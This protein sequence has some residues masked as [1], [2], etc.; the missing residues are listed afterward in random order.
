MNHKQ[1]GAAAVEFAL[2]APAV[3]LIIFASFEYLRVTLMTCAADVASYEAA[4]AVMVPGAKIE[5]AKFEA[6]KYL[7]YLGSRDKEILVQPIDS[8]GIVQNEIDDLTSRIH[9]CIRIPVRSNVLL[10]SRF[11]GDIVIESNTTL[12]FESYSG[13][14][15]RL[16]QLDHFQFNKYANLFQNRVCLD[17]AIEPDWKQTARGHRPV[18]GNHPA[19]IVVVV[20]NRGQHCLHAIKSHRTSCRN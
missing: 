12:A 8:N 15:R 4:R 7:N 16:I 6:G 18:D 2:I 13:F 19:G 10:L 3:F 11:F 1:R 9:V 14:L 20:R 5:E 17:Y